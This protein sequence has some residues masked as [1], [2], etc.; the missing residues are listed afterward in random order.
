M[1][2]CIFYL[3]IAGFCLVL[4]NT[5]FVNGFDCKNC[6]FGCPTHPYHSDALHERKYYIKIT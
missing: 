1:N 5:S 6:S 3:I 2:Q 4:T